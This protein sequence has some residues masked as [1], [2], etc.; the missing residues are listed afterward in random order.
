MSRRKPAPDLIRGGDRFA[1]QDMRRTTSVRQ[2]EAARAPWF[3]CARMIAIR[4][5]RKTRVKT[6]LPAG[7]IAALALLATPA[8]AADTI[9]MAVQK[10]GTVAWELAVIRAHGFDRDAGLDLVAVELAS[11]EAG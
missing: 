11:P 7:M 5:R 8:L 6:S 9:R 2:V 1:D 3:R 4:N 10:T